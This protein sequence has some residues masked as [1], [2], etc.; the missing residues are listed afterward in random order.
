VTEGGFVQ[1]DADADG[2]VLVFAVKPAKVLAFGKG[3]FS[4]TRYRPS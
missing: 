1:A 3:T 2:P 4:H